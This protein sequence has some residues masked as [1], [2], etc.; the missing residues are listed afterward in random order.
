MKLHANAKT[1]PKTRLLLVHRIEEEGWDAASSAQALVHRFW[2]YLKVHTG[3][4]LA[5]RLPSRLMPRW[6]RKQRSQ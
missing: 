4:Q 2:S 6:W 3:A 1:T 5:V